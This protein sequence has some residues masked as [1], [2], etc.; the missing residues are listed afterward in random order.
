MSLSNNL[1]ICKKINCG[2]PNNP[3]AN[4]CKEC[5]ELLEKKSLKGII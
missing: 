1:I 4:Y 3:K 2:I 5:G